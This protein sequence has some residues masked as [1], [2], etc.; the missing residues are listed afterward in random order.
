MTGP[1]PPATDSLYATFTGAELRAGR[2]RIAFC[3]GLF[4]Q[5]K[6][7]TTIARRL[8]DAYSCALIDMPNHG[9]SGWTEELGYPAM[10]DQLAG[11][12]AGH[13]DRPWVLVGHSMGAKIAMI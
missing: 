5:G 8:G 12:L 1:H 9:R 11:F 7:W 13:G 10:S 3:H 4:G 2:P 6:N